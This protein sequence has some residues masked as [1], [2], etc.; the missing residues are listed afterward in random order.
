MSSGSL[1]HLSTSHC[2]NIPR[3]P[4]TISAIFVE[5]RRQAAGVA[6]E[7]DDRAGDARA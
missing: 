3:E 1:R 5:Q 2:G 7:E 6:L 4:A